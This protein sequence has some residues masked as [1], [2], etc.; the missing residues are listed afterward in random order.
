MSLR[1][2][3]EDYEGSTTIVPLAESQVTIGRKDG[4]TIQLTE[5]NVSREHARLSMV[6][7][8]WFLEDL[9]SYNGV[10]VNAVPIE[11]KVELNESD[12]ITIADYTLVLCENAERA[13]ALLAPRRAANDG[14]AISHVSAPQPMVQ[15]SADLPEV[16]PP[17]PG[18]YSSD[19]M[20]AMPYE[21]PEE[22]TSKAAVLLVLVAAVVL[23]GVV[24][25]AMSRNKTDAGKDKAVAS[26]KG[27]D[28]AD[29]ATTGQPAQEGPVPAETGGEVVEPAAE[30]GEVEPAEGGELDPDAEGGEVMP[31]MGESGGVEPEPAEGGEI[32][33]DA[34]GGEVEPEPKTPVKKKKKKKKP[35]G[36]TPPP[37]KPAADPDQLLADARKA[38]M[39][40]NASKAYKLAK[41]AYGINS[42]SEALQLM[43]VSACKMGDE[44]KAKSAYNKMSGSKKK[45]LATLCSSKGIEL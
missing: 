42:S 6:D 16:P 5:Q 40:G 8:R 35:G 1:L 37:P 34:E 41:Q 30:T 18:M 28:V 45:S 15:S 23:G 12:L 20:G 10:K 29:A 13:A 33:P 19:Q 11:G 3:I 31:E 24:W 36:E 22:K 9:G 7:D 2:V 44:S 14:E 21:P 39:G 43:G 17:D 26:D 38:S 25:F 27:T 32:E 4:N